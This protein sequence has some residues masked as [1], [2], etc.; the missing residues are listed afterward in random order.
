MTPVLLLVLESIGT[1]ELI[2]IAIA[3]LVLFGPRRLPEI[4]RTLGKYLADFRRVSDE[5]KNTWQS[6]VELEEATVRRRTTSTDDAPAANENTGGDILGL[7]VPASI[8]TTNDAG[9]GS[10]SAVNGDSKDDLATTND[11]PP[12]VAVPADAIVA[13]NT[14]SSLK[15]RV[16]PTAQLN[17]EEPERA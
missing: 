5:F 7:G 17:Q 4:G 14:K 12:L 9:G 16:D 8:T 13:R 2:L 15:T 11:V 3:A 10:A 1:Q 6:E